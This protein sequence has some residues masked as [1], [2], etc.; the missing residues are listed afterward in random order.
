MVLGE[1]DRTVLVKTS[2]CGAAAYSS[3]MAKM[4]FSNLTSLVLS[5]ITISNIIYNKQEHYDKVTARN[6]WNAEYDFV[7]V[8]GGTAGCVLAARLSEDP[9]V[10]VLLMEAGGSETVLSNTPGLSESLLGTMLDWKHLSISQNHSCQSMNNRQ[11]LLSSGRVIGGTSSVNR[12][13]YLRG[14]PTDFD[15]WENRLG[16][17]IVS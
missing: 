2:S 11:C 17:P 16:M 12:M 14:N 8:G 3:D 6:R 9:A 7:I 4:G 13:Y 5:F 15:N 1:S 10:T